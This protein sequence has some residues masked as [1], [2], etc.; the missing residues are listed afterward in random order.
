MQHSDIWNLVDP[1]RTAPSLGWPTPGDNSQ[2]A[3]VSCSDRPPQSPHPPLLWGS[4]LGATTHLLSPP[5]G[6]GACHLG[7]A[8]LPRALCNYS[9]QPILTLFT[10]PHPLLS[11]ETAGQVLVHVFPF[12]GLVTD[13]GGSAGGPAWCRG[14][15]P[16][17]NYE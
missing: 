16:L 2:G 10:Q 1:G 9:K 17:G 11:T 15:L 6:P 8:P 13:P 5:P 7:A 3:R 12:P 4:Y 14:P